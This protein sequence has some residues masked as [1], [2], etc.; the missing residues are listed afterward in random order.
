MHMENDR[1]FSIIIPQINKTNLYDSTLMLNKSINLSRCKRSRACLITTVLY[2]LLTKSGYLLLR[3]N[4]QLSHQ[5]LF[6]NRLP[7][8]MTKINPENCY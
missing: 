6:L 3:F 7:Y 8:R 1:I 5:F 2:F 4:Q